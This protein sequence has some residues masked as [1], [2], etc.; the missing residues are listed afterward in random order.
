[1]RVFA[2]FHTNRL[3]LALQSYH[4]ERPGDEVWPLAPLTVSRRLVPRCCNVGV[5]TFFCKFD[6]FWR[7]PLAAALAT[8]PHGPFAE[9][10]FSR[11]LHLLRRSSLPAFPLVTFFFNFPRFPLDVGRLVEADVAAVAGGYLVPSGVDVDAMA[12]CLKGLDRGGRG[13][14]AA[15]ASRIFDVVVEE[16]VRPWIRGV[17]W[18]V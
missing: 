11:D 1:M 6:I 4:E 18:N 8:L 2:K 15:A 13:P 14:G 17:S 9:H 3:P 10:P 16:P 12:V 7:V 5:R